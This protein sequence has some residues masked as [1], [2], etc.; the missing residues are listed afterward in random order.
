ML[1]FEYYFW[2]ELVETEKIG[3]RKDRMQHQ[4]SKG[5]CQRLLPFAYKWLRV[6]G[7]QRKSASS[8][9]G[10]V[11]CQHSLSLRNMAST[12]QWCSGR[13][14]L[15]G[16]TALMQRMFWGTW[17]A[18]LWEI[19]S[20]AREVIMIIQTPIFGWY[21]MADSKHTLIMVNTWS[22]IL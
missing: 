21:Q 4:S 6:F 12:R 14:A 10:L 20:S 11:T 1:F 13:W 9:L 15:S 18:G 7:A 22:T 5:P 3:Q 19:G 2:M 17:K 16:Q 8:T